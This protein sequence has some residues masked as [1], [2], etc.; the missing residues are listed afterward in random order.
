VEEV[1]NRINDNLEEVRI[2]LH[3]K[4]INFP[5]VDKVRNYFN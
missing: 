3:R 5:K 2:A 1:R 4:K